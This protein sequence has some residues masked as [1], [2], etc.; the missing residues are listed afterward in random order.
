M[1]ILQNYVIITDST[2][3]LS[4]N[5]IEK[6]DVQILPLTFNI[7]G[8]VYQDLPDWSEL[9]LKEFYSL[10]KRGKTSSTSQINPETF[11][12]EFT[13]HL[14]NDMDILYISFSS[15]L[16]GTFQSANIAKQKLLKDYPERKIIIVDSLCASMGEGLLVYYAAKMRSNG[17][18]IL[19]LENWLNQNKLNLCHWFTVDD[20]HHLKRGGRISAAVALIGSMLNIKPILHV[21]N[22]GHLVLMEKARGRKKSLD[23]LV[24]KVKKYGSNLEKQMIFISHGDCEEDAKYVAEKIKQQCN[25]EDVIINAVGPVIG[26]HSGPGTVAVFFVGNKR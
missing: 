23:T 26:S 3:D 8:K 17:I 21:D 6:L 11:I 9:P 19:N 24:E 5:L 7:D 25:V 12:K 15:G 4:P 10:I 18:D 22:S 14:K 16:S 2:T 20:L 1:F 13:T